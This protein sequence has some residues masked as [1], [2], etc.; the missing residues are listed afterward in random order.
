[1]IG[2]FYRHHTLLS[3]FNDNFLKVKLDQIAK[4][5]SKTCILLG[6]W[7]ANLLE[8]D[9]HEATENFYE[10]L[11][12]HTYQ[13]LILQPSRVTSKSATLID[14]IFVNDLGISCYGGNIVTSISDHFPQFSFLDILKK[15]KEKPK[16]VKA[17]S[18]KNFNDNEFRNELSNMNWNQLFENKSSEDSFTIFIQ[19]IDKLLDEMAPVKVL[20]KKEV[21]L[22]NKP[23][24]TR[25]ILNSIH[26][27]D[28]IYKRYLKEKN[29]TTKTALFN[30]FKYKR[31][32][33]ILLLRKSKKDY[34][35]RYF[36][37]NKT[38]I[39]ETWQGIKNIINLNKKS[40][41]NI[42]K[43]KTSNG[44]LTNK[45]DI[46]TEFNN[47]FSTIGNNIDKKTPRTTKKFTEYL[48]DRNNN[49]LLLS[50]VDSQ[51]II[52]LINQIKDCKA[53]GPSSI[54]NK[55]LKTHKD[56]FSTL[57]TTLVNKSFID[58]TFPDLLKVANLIPIYKKRKNSFVII[59]DLYRFCQT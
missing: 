14:N 46:A 27:R 36:T 28:K 30:K 12:S 17:R 48:P 55:L 47:F 9:N 20:S 45:K 19:K 4:E 6:D 13:P 25:G 33:I 21:K 11:S 52:N 5:K 8:C 58:G 53:C 29:K 3:K 57:L 44:Y 34:Y 22:E 37:D 39:K 7:N 18:Y 15:H 41:T 16:L 51:E 50:T 23:W 35:A 54:P 2:C 32:M 26:D 43:I 38:N 24:I 49:Q 56:I 59:T 42:N 31:N 40:K 1:M 10:L